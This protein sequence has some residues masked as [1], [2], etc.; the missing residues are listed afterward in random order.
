MTTGRKLRLE[1]AEV[2]EPLLEPA[3]Y[4]AAWGGRGSGKSNFFAG[5]AVE[6][7]LLN[8]PT[9]VVCIREVQRVLAQSSKKLVDDTIR[10]FELQGEFEI[11][12]DRIK[13]PG[14]GLIIFHGMQDHTAESIKVAGR[15]RHSVGRR[16]V[17]TLRTFLAALEAHNQK[18]GFGTVVRV[19]PRPEERC[20]GRTMVP[21]PLWSPMPNPPRIC[22]KAALH[23][24]PRSNSRLS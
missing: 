24:P 10:Q 6:R 2:F 3:R 21:I 14:G 13:T 16:G 23:R 20:G 8:R 4:K 7:C 15:L 12:A 11:Q 1:T 5:A 9:I 18:A 17:S 19:E 22:Y